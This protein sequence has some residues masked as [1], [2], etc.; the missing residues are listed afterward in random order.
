M[1]AVTELMPFL[2][3]K[4]Q[5]R[6]IGPEIEALA[7]ALRNERSA[8]RLEAGAFEERFADYRNVRCRRAV[9]SGV[10]GLFV[11][12]GAAQAHGAEYK[13]RRAG[14]I[15][16]LGCFSFYPD[17]NLGACGEVGAVVTDHPELAGRVSRLLDQVQGGE[18]DHVLARYDDRMDEV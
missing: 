17:K 2:E 12:E 5:A 13:S 4:T 14:S 7:R 1:S 11:I 10:H 15:G 18:R 9:S 8:L 3:L 6:T 16:D